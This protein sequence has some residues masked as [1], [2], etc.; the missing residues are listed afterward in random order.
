MRKS[1]QLTIK[2]D[3]TIPDELLEK[4]YEK[5]EELTFKLAN[6]RKE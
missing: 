5:L 1:N 2:T 6:K 4:V 3:E